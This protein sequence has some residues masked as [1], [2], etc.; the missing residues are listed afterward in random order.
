MPR[1]IATKPPFEKALKVYLEH[2]YQASQIDLPRDACLLERYL[3]E[4]ASTAH[5]FGRVMDG[6]LVTLSMAELRRKAI[7]ASTKAASTKALPDPTG[8]SPDHHDR[9]E[10]VGDWLEFYRTRYKKQGSSL[11]LL[12][13]PR[14]SWPKE[15]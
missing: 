11:R 1:R 4:Q 15:S 9:T 2:Q 5:D 12:S 14:I 13:P 3:R 6:R 10:K 7:R 8:L